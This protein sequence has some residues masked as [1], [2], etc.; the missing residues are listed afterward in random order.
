MTALERRTQ[1]NEKRSNAWLRISKQALERDYQKAYG[2]A[3]K[4]LDEMYLLQLMVQT[5]PVL[6]RGL[7]DNTSKEVLSLLNKL[8]KRSVFYKI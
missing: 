3:L 5:G 2:S 8:N 7:T 1:R 4:E 6:S